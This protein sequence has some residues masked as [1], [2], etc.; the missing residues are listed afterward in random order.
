MND[1]ITWHCINQGFC[2]FK[3]KIKQPKE[4]F[5]RNEYNVTGL[6]NR[7]SCPLANSE[8]ATIVE[9]EGI[10]YLYMKT[11]ERA[12][13][14]NRMWE[15]IELSRNY[16]EALKQIDTHMLHWK[17]HQINR[18]KQRLTKLRQYIVRQRKIALSDNQVSLVG[19]KQKTEKR[20]RTR[21]AKAEKAAKVELSIEQEL[22]ERL[23]QG[24]YGS[25]YNE[26]QIR[27]KETDMDE[28]EELETAEEDDERMM[29]FVAAEDDDEGIAELLQS[30][31]EEDAEREYQQELK[32][33]AKTGGD[34]EDYYGSSSSKPVTRKKKKP[35]VEIEYE[36]DDEDGSKAYA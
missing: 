32:E 7:V 35:K 22:M 33:L 34:I 24:T 27:D 14:P 10:C 23:R 1:E 17:D 28:I 25:L 2:S 36:Y 3:V 30:D 11:V 15:K 18:C 5:C 19:I 4:T 21:E 16:L 20:E 9:K 8:Y 31:G 6:C 12:H 13:T 29:E 26:E